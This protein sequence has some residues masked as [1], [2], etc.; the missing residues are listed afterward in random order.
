MKCN[1]LTDFIDSQITKI[2]THAISIE[3]VTA[4]HKKLKSRMKEGQSC[5]RESFEKFHID[6]ESKIEVL[7]TKTHNEFNGIKNTMIDIPNFEKT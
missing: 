1:K 3:K 6:V 5:L 7:R 4:S 2:S